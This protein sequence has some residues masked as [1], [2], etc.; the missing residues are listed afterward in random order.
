[1]LFDSVCVC[2]SFGLVTKLVMFHG[3]TWWSSY[4]GS[5]ER[6]SKRGKLPVSTCQSLIMS[7]RLTF[8]FFF[9]GEAPQ[10]PNKVIKVPTQFSHV[11]SKCLDSPMLYL[12]SACLFQTSRY[13]TGI[14]EFVLFSLRRN[15]MPFTKI[16]VFR[17]PQG[18]TRT[19]NT[20]I[21]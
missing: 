19:S 9:L 16:L 3:Q 4:S 14:L 21:Q 15:S 17:G 8:P 18:T 10:Q 1:L 2:L 20:Q 13:M 5:Q 7:Q 12:S 6:H 11:G